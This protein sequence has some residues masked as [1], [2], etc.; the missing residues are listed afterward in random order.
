MRLYVP[1]S[2]VY[3]FTQT[4][5]LPTRCSP[6]RHIYWLNVVRALSLISLVLLFAS[7]LVVVVHD[8]QAVN[9]FELAKSLN[10]TAVIDNTLDCDYIECIH[11]LFFLF[12]RAHNLFYLTVAAPCQINPQV[13]FGP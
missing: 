11:F 10:D 9:H 13:P 12:D 2:L 6:S 4:R 7:S 5:W 3:A 8:I 1:V